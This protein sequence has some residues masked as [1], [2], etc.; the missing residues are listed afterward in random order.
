MLEWYKTDH[1]EEIRNDFV[2]WFGPCILL[3]FNGFAKEKKY[4]YYSFSCN[5]AS[6]GYIYII[7]IDIYN[8]ISAILSSCASK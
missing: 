2:F 3:K 6:I 8:K 7:F 1:T 5:S 4:K